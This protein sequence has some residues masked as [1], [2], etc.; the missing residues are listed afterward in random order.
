[1]TT[2]IDMSKHNELRG[3][4]ETKMFSKMIPA[5][6]LSLDQNDLKID[7]LEE[8]K[9]EFE[10]VKGEWKKRVDAAGGSLLLQFNAKVGLL[11]DNYTRMV[12]SSVNEVSGE[13]EPRHMSYKKVSWFRYLFVESVVSFMVQS[14]C[15]L[16]NFYYR[17]EIAEEKAAQEFEANRWNEE[18]DMILDI[19]DKDR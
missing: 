5:F 3:E 12:Q 10:R 8:Y 18:N 17:K 16:N 9:E 19:I 7:T 13:M 2:P 14:Y 1:M 4:V 6:V 15:K 11:G